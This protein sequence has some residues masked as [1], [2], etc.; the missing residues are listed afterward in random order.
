MRF[1]ICILAA[2]SVGWGEEAAAPAAD[3]PAPSAPASAPAP[4]KIGGITIQGS[5]RTRVE[6]W[7][8]FQADTGDN[9]YAYSG[10]LFRLS[11]SQSLESF[12]W[13]LEFAVPILLAL[14]GN[15]V[16]AGAQ[17][18]L[19]MG[20]S[21]YVANNKSKNAAMPFAKQ[22]F[23]RFK[24]GAKSFRAGRFEFLD[25]SE[26]TPKNAKLAAIKR[27]RVVQRLI[28]NFGFSHVQ[29]SFDG[30]QYLYS[31]PSGTFT[32]MGARPTRG[33]FQT[34]GWGEV[35]TAFGYT[36]YTRPWSQA[37]YTSETRLMGIYYDDWRPVLKDRQPGAG[38]AP[39]G[40]RQHPYL[41][42]RRPSSEHIGH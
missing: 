12:D 10:S 21:Y 15:A 5:L 8:W 7:N 6:D 40:P 9:A 1:C 32:F 4:I 25:G 26:A 36:A 20:A 18:Q 16:A 41:H 28:G 34:D 23:I 37:A 3:A 35:D 29:R 31:A 27:D 33:V 22:G 2:A 39:R 30:V 13:Q 14:P 11:L 17:G 24:G 42:L 38:G 19:G